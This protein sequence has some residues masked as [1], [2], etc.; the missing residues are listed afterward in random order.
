MITKVKK[1]CRNCS[2]GKEHG[3]LTSV[4]EISEQAA[5]LMKDYIIGMG[6]KK[7]AVICDENTVKFAR[8]LADAIS[9]DLI[10]I[11]P[12]NAH[13]TEVYT[14]LTHK[15]LSECDADAAVACGA[16]S[17]HDITRYSAF[18][19]KIPFI[20]YPTAASVDG[21]VSGVA[22]MTWHGQKLTFP[23]APPAAVFADPNVFSDAPARLT[24][25]GAGD[26]YGKYTSLFDWKTSSILTGEH[27]CEEIAAL[28]Y[29]ALDAVTAVVNNKDNIS[30]KEYT[31][32]VME[33]LLLSG[34]A[35]QLMGN[36][37][38]ASGSEHHMSH[39][40]EMH[41]INEETDALHGE[42]VAVGLMCVVKKYA[43][44]LEN[45]VFTVFS[46][47]KLGKYFS[48][49]KLDGVFGGLTEG[50]IREN[51]PNGVSSLS[52]ITEKGTAKAALVKEAFK[53]I[54]S[55][56]ELNALL[57]KAEVPTT[58]HGI[59]LP[60]HA[61]FIEKSLHYAPYVRDRLSLLKI[62]SASEALS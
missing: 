42:K 24:A 35:M 10:Y 48:A 31:V 59:N 32:K 19:K 40:W 27:Y 9:T 3:L 61:D 25:S 47:E 16:G 60:D 23:S 33:A 37:R 52:K 21:F 2:C 30:V 17:V 57:E 7:A 45:G 50:I 1:L 8:P 18:E 56:E 53:T 58:L 6:Y 62:I 14:A 11:L 39:L 41:C 49:E 38:P 13:A 20:S 5:Q 4:C 54:P 15:F 51:L 46:D 44:W 29:D 43:E 34:L 36:S 55:Y 22:A 28:E 12:G 26:V